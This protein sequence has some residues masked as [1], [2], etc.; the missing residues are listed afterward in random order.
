MA[1]PAPAVTPDIPITP[2]KG[3]NKKNKS[4]TTGSKKPSAQVIEFDGPLSLKEIQKLKLTKDSSSQL[5]DQSTADTTESEGAQREPESKP[6]V[7]DLTKYNS[8]EICGVMINRYRNASKKFTKIQSIEKEILANPEVQLTL[9]KNELL[10]NRFTPEATIHE[11]NSLLPIINNVFESIKKR[12]LEAKLSERPVEEPI[13]EKIENLIEAPAEKEVDVSNSNLLLVPI[14]Q[15]VASLC[16]IGKKRGPLSIEETDLLEKVSE[17]FSLKVDESNLV[18]NIKNFFGAEGVS[19]EKTSILVNK[20]FNDELTPLSPPTPIEDEVLPEPTIE[21]DP[22]LAI[23]SLE[24]TVKDNVLFYTKQTLKADFKSSKL[25]KFPFNISEEEIMSEDLNFSEDDDCPGIVIKNMFKVPENGINFTSPSEVFAPKF[26]ANGTELATTDIK[27]E[28]GFASPKDDPTSILDS[29]PSKE[30]EQESA[31]LKPQEQPQLPPATEKSTQLL[32]NKESTVEKTLA[33]STPKSSAISSSLPNSHPPP[34]QHPQGFAPGYPSYPHPG[35]PMHPMTPQGTTGTYTTGPPYMGPGMGTHPMP[36]PEHFYPS[37]NMGYNYPPYGNPGEHYGYGPPPAGFVSGGPT[38]PASYPP[39]GYPYHPTNMPPPHHHP[40][41]NPY[42]GSNPVIKPEARPIAIRHPSEKKT[43]TKS[44]SPTPSKEPTNEADKP[45][46]IIQKE[47]K[48]I[49]N[50]ADSESESGEND[51]Y[52]VNSQL[53][54]HNNSKPSNDF[55]KRGPQS[56]NNYK[57]KSEELPY[58]SQRPPYN[59]NNEHGYQSH[60]PV[61]PNYGWAPPQPNYYS[62]PHH[63]APPVNQTQTHNRRGNYNNNNNHSRNY[64][65]NYRGNSNR[66]PTTNSN[67]SNSSQ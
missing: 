16:S 25:G 12:E 54:S 36:H 64:R 30:Q 14:A 18:H 45:E 55:V 4:K 63:Q 11:L 57:F 6:K 22:I 20:V 2:T 61:P 17:S 1:S 8:H 28:S 62:H 49:N 52:T 38:D 51:H 58:E 34:P 37:P 21:A 33:Q 9:E 35:M 31:L 67:G 66:R 65:G 41:H 15:L 40:Y 60:H 39:N 47:I 7:L 50:W 32:E 10:E 27:P 56:N 42:G 48:H 5:E 44:K 29:T 24:P 53:S 23:N 59:N 43:G 26:K 13:E 46:N 3:K 19:E